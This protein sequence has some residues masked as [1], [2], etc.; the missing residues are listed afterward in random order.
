[1]VLLGHKAHDIRVLTFKKAT[2]DAKVSET[3]DDVSAAGSDLCKFASISRESAQKFLEHSGRDN[4]AKRLF[5]RN[6]GLAE[7]DAY[8]VGSKG[9]AFVLSYLELH[10]SQVGSCFVMG[11]SKDRLPHQV[12]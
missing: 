7:G 1:M 2:D 3:K 4:S 5:A 12:P 11:G 6:S 8:S 9:T 10:P